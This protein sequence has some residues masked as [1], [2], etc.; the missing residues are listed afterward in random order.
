MPD[1]V[2]DGIPNTEEKCPGY[3]TLNNE[4]RDGDGIGDDCDT[5]DDRK[6]T[7]TPGGTLQVRFV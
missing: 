1:L 6:L 3:Y 2:G 4:D 7:S 5:K